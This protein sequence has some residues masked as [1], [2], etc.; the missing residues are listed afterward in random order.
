MRP[1][2][3]AAIIAAGCLLGCQASALAQD[4]AEH[5]PAV[6]PYAGTYYGQQPLYDRYGAYYDR[7]G[8]QSGT[9]D[10]YNGQYYPPDFQ[11]AW[12]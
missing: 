11:P 1:K 4:L 9:F 7:Y 3:M 8:G 2:L 6:Y 5:P 12:H 10:P